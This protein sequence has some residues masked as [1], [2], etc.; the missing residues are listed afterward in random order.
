MNWR[1]TKKIIY[2]LII[3]IL[4]PTCERANEENIFSPSLQVQ[5]EDNLDNEVEEVLFE[6]ISHLS[7]T[8]DLLDATLDKMKV[9]ISNNEKE[10][11]ELKKKVELLESQ[12]RKKIREERRVQMER[13]RRSTQIPRWTVP[14]PQYP[15]GREE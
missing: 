3:I 8:L 12:E 11:E 10:I 5:K 7:T 13:E 2:I 15:S 1:R 6:F 14:L 9:Q 4:F